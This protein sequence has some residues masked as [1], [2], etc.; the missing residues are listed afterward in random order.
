MPGGR[1]EELRG[2]RSISER[3]KARKRTYNSALRLC[4][5]DAEAPEGLP[6]G[7]RRDRLG[8]TI[9][10]AALGN[11]AKYKINIHASILVQINN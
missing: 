11:N 3:Q 8:N 4:R 9:N 7:Q 5:R 6:G 10:S 2:A 1:R